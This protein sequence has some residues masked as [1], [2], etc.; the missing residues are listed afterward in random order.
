MGLGATGSRAGRPGPVLPLSPSLARRPQRQNGVHGTVNRYRPTKEQVDGPWA[1]TG[2]KLDPDAVMDRELARVEAHMTELCE[3]TGPTVTAAAVRDHLAAGGQR[4]RAR[5]ALDA[6]RRLGLPPDRRVAIASASELL[7]NAS[8]VHD[9]IQDGDTER[10]DRRA[11]WAEYGSCVGICVGDLFLSA[12]YAALAG[13]HA[14]T[15]ELLVHAH[16]RVATAI[17]GQTADLRAAP[18]MSDINTY[19]SIAGAKSGGLLALP[20]ELSLL[21]VG[22]RDALAM[23]AA[24]AE[25]FA[26]G[27]QIVDDL[28]DRHDDCLRE[29][30]NILTV[31]AAGGEP[32]PAAAATALAITCFDDSLATSCNLPAASGTLVGQRARS[33]R[34]AVNASTTGVP[35]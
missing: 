26:I 7:H 23:A 25:A 20:L 11:I 28:A 19:F 15:A 13:A 4:F 27:Y 10:R 24:A 22:R 3:T 16:S 29:Q 18:G 21:A 35:A 5:L 2:A 33:L 9:D 6:G 17:D 31:L 34:R 30:L 1:V 12:A 8:L 32:D 14:N